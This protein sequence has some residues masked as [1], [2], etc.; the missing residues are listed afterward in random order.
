MSDLKEQVRE[1]YRAQLGEA[2]HRA[3][4]SHDESVQDVVARSR[5]RKL[6]PFVKPDDAV[7]EFGVGTNVNLRFLQCRRRVGY[8]VNDVARRACERFGVEYTSDLGGMA[9]SFTVVVCHHVLEHVADPFATL[10]TITTLLEPGGTLILCVPFETLR[11]YR[12]Y[13]PGDR[14]H[15]LFSWNALTLGNLVSDAGFRVE[16]VRVS[17]F[18]FEQRLAFLARYGT[19]AYRMGLWLVRTVVPTEEV[20]LVARK[21]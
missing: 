5:A 10:E 2:Y 4:S 18:G 14:N 17:P 8:D 9:G 15:H 7:V 20:F 12:R 16:S 3:V 1:R 11:R 19:C 13:R 21:A 6:Q